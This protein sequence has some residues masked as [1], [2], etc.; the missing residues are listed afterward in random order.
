MKFQLKIDKIGSVIVWY[1]YILKSK[2]DNRFYTG[3]TTNLER[4]LNQ[5]SIGNRATR[6]TINR[7]P[8]TLIFVQEC[9]NRLQARILEKYLKSGTGRELRNSLFNN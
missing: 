2:K 3:I 7:G 1:V 5:H 4:R 9:K 6:S 8:F